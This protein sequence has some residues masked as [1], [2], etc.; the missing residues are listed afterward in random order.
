MTVRRSLMF[1]AL[2]LIAGLT[3]GGAGALPAQ[4]HAVVHAVLFYSP[5]CPHCHKVI[6]EDLPGIFARFGGP[7][8]LTQGTAGHVLSN[9]TLEVLLVNV[10]YAEGLAAFEASNRVLGIPADDLGVPR[11]VCGTQW[12]V[13]DRDIPADFPKLITEGLASGGTGWP[14]IAGL[15]RVFPDGYANAV[16]V[17]PTDST[18][19][20]DTVVAADTTVPTERAVRTAPPSTVVPTDT[21]RPTRRENIA[22][23]REQPVAPP[24]SSVPDTETAT[25]TAVAAAPV[26][27]PPDTT[28]NIADVLNSGQTGSVI[29]RTFRADP[30]GTSI[31]IGLILVMLFS[32]GWMSAKGP[33]HVKVPDLTV[34]VLVV[35]GMV[36]AT[37]LAYVEMTGAQAVCGPVGDCNSVQQ[38]A[39]AKVFGIPVALIGLAGYA[40][41]IATWALARRSR[42]TWGRR[43]LYTLTVIGTAAS[44]ALTILEPFVIGAVCLWCCG[45]AAVM[46]ALLWTAP[47]VATDPTVPSR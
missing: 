10:S 24:P 1:R 8:Q 30:V 28:A 23:T 11:L 39:Y 20:T 21:L 25:D 3:L 13:G 5:T 40:A 47:A 43:M 18:V 37:Y 17:A 26:A 34:P 35:L 9:G 4:Q 32:L 38:S 36:M 16:A 7:P 12:L 6:M 27:F 42:I 2:V 15:D 44:L 22:E 19:A 31:A 29:S 14:E 33:T 41:I 45:S 46:T